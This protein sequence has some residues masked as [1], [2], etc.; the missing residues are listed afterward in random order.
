MSANLG[1][2]PGR[3][4]IT[5][6]A[7]TRKLDKLFTLSRTKLD[8]QDPQTFAPAFEYLSTAAAILDTVPVDSV[9]AGADNEIIDMAN[10]TRCVSGAFYNLAGSLYRATRYGAAVPFLKESCSLGGK[11]L[12][13]PRSVSKSANQNEWQQL[14]E[15]LFRRW[16]L[17]AV[18]Y[19]KNG[20]QKV[21][22]LSLFG[23][24]LTHLID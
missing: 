1:P 9:L 16:E 12:R 13:L 24:Q 8:V 14:E 7:L 15:Q 18:C 17:L 6:D 20:D 21:G 5:K 10:Y 3:A 23:F 11:A 22:I 2:H 4:S 19:S